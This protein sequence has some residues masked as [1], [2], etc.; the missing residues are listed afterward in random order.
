MALNSTFQVGSASGFPWKR[1]LVATTFWSMKSVTMMWGGW[2]PQWIVW[3]AWKLSLPKNA[4]IEVP[5]ICWTQEIPG[6]RG[7]PFA[8]LFERK[9]TINWRFVMSKGSQLAHFPLEWKVQ[10]LEEKLIRMPLL[11]AGF[12]YWGRWFPFAGARGV[13]GYHWSGHVGGG[14]I[15]KTLCSFGL[16][17]T[18]DCCLV[19]VMFYSWYSESVLVMIE[20]CSRLS[21]T[22]CCSIGDYFSRCWMLGDVS[23]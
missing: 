4:V 3:Q 20:E 17:N 18:P 21:R 15:L 12:A 14:G 13:S 5:K 2:F 22:G 1:P 19:N 9:L 8:Q 10:I 7:L 6:L 16:T 11:M 23:I